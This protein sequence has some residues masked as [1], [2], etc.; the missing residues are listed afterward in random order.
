MNVLKKI[1]EIVQ[2]LRLRVKTKNTRQEERTGK[3]AGGQK[4]HKGTTKLMTDNPDEIIELYPEKCTCCGENHFIKKEKILKKRQIFDIP[5]I[6]PFVV[7]YQQKAGICTKC[8]SR[9]TG[10]FPVNA[11]VNFGTRITG[12]IGYL[13]VQ[14]TKQIV[15]NACGI[16]LL[17]LGNYYNLNNSENVPNSR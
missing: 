16:K 14:H 7:E 8:G 3:K 17:L 6:K 2:C 10:E 1:Q 5:E 11:P 9:N 12:I 13:N 15:L 4:G